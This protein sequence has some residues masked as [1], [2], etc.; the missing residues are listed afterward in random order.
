MA[1]QQKHMRKFGFG[2]MVIA[3]CIGAVV[4]AFA[5]GDPGTPPTTTTNAA[6]DR[7]YTVQVADTLE[8]IGQRLNVSV[9]SLF[10][11]NGLTY[12]DF[13][14]PGDTIIVPAD[15]APFG[16]Y[17]ARTGYMGS[18]EDGLG[19]YVIQPQDVV[20]LVA[21]F[22]DVDLACLAQRNDLAD[23]NLVYPGLALLIPADCPA[24]SGLSSVPVNGLRGINVG[25]SARMMEIIAAR[26]PVVGGGAI[27]IGGTATTAAPVSTSVP[28]TATTSSARPTATATV[29]ITP[30]GSGVISGPTVTPTA[31]G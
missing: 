26:T 11:A 1:Q 5:G 27:N 16:F 3:V 23:A 19:V 8:T 20:D 2:L 30:G 13:I 6:G 31:G 28:A 25:A 9:I 29:T 15:A 21:A 17:P 14:F 24:Y 7:V 10:D 18:R 4:T 12:A 22:F